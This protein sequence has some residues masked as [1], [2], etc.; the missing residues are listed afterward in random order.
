MFEYTVSKN[1]S[2][3]FFAPIAIAYSIY[4]IAWERIQETHQMRYQKMVY[5]PERDYVTFGYLPSQF[6]LSVLCL[7]VRNV[8]APYSAD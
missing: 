1:M 2:T 6:C 8:R 7:S 4:H 5:I 3:Y